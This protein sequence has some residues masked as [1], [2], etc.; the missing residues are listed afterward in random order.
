MKIFVKKHHCLSCFQ[1]HI[2]TIGQFESNKDRMSFLCEKTMEN[3]IFVDKQDDECFSWTK[4]FVFIWFRS[5][6][7]TGKNLLINRS[8]KGS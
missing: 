5:T 8:L 4:V 3:I 7:F 1:G 2:S 6:F